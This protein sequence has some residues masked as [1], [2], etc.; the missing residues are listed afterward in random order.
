MERCARKIKNRDRLGEA[1]GLLDPRSR[2]LMELWLTGMDR[3]EIATEMRLCDAAAAA[4]F[5][6]AFR[7]VRALLAH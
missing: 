3:H 2:R 5:D 4:L 7:Q 6:T 1:L